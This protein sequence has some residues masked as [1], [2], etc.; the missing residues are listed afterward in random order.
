M[1]VAWVFR[2]PSISRIVLQA[3][4]N[5]STIDVVTARVKSEASDSR[6]FPS[7][8]VIDLA[9]IMSSLAER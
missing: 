1:L 4:R 3:H 8:A 9:Q 2:C 5:K 6:L 7:P